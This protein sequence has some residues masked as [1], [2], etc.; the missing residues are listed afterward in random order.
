MVRLAYVKGLKD[1]NILLTSEPGRGQRLSG[2]LRRF[3]DFR[4]TRFL[5]VFVGRVTQPLQFLEELLRLEKESPGFLDSVS[6]LVPIDRSFEFSVNDFEER[7]KDALLPYAD[8]IKSGS[9]YV[10]IERRGHKGEIHS[11][12]VEQD[13]GRRLIEHLGTRGHAPTL[14]FKDPDLILVAETLDETCGVTALPRDMRE[15]F[16]F[17]RVR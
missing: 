6:K 7:L 3:G 2:L 8:Q 13:L 12:H 14:K 4:R 15:R 17:I 10:R 9:F 11:Q 5:G 16:P 1:W